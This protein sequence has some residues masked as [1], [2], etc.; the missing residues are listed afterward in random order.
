MTE[1]MAMFWG[2]DFTGEGIEEDEA[3]RYRIL[4]TMTIW[5][6]NHLTEEQRRRFEALIPPYLRDSRLKGIPSPGMGMIYDVPESVLGCDSFDVSLG[7]PHALMVNP[8]NLIPDSSFRFI[9]GMDL[10]FSNSYS[11]FVWM[12]YDSITKTIYA[13]DCF[14]ARHQT[15]R[16]IAP[17][18]KKWDKLLGFSI[19]VSWPKDVGDQGRTEGEVA[20]DLYVTEGINMLPI[21]AAVEVGESRSRNKDDMILNLWN[22]MTNGQFKVFKDGRMSPWWNQWKMYRIDET[23]KIVKS[24]KHQFDLMD[25]TENGAAMVERYGASFN[26][27]MML[28]LQTQANIGYDPYSYGQGSQQDYYW[29]QRMNLQRDTIGG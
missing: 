7:S 3:A 17:A 13:F 26:S 24:K 25:A 18:L 12:V 21:C 23:G 1:L 27:G 4:I 2:I 22:K 9:V 15:P 19:P 29:N 14:M 5:E 6:A 10:G 8:F 16:Q 20:K 28:N 11:A